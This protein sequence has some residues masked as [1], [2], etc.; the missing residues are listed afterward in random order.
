[1]S[2]KRPGLYKPIKEAQC[3]TQAEKAVKKR[4]LRI[5]D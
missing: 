2:G 1:M 3:Y 4:G 5:E